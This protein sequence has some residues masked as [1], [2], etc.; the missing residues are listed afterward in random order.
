VE[1]LFEPAWSFIEARRPSSGNLLPPDFY[2]VYAR[3]V[4][5]FVDAAAALA[6]TD[7]RDPAIDICRELLTLSYDKTEPDQV[8]WA[9]CLLAGVLSGFA[10]VVKMSAGEQGFL[11]A[12]K[13][14]LMDPL[15]KAVLLPKLTESGLVGVCDFL[16]VVWD[17][18]GRI[19]RCRVVIRSQRVFKLLAWARMSKDNGIA[20]RAQ[21]LWDAISRE[22]FR[23][24]GNGLG[25]N[26][27]WR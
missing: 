26:R 14:R 22:E 25:Q 8:E 6:R 16:S 2:P 27:T 13:A 12:A 11:V 7:I 21:D 10:A 9:N 5:Q 23:T 17:V 1:S 4:A 24:I 18:M 20:K 19:Q 3:A 15:G